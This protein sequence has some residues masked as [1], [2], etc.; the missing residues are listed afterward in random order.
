[1]SAPRVRAYE[2]ADEAEV[3][4]IFRATVAFGKPI[5]FDLTRMPAYERLCLDWFLGPGA[6][7]AGVLHDNGRVLGYIL[8]CTDLV[9]FRR[10]SVLAGASWVGTTLGRFLTGR[11]RGPEARFHLLRLRDGIEASQHAPPAPMPGYVH[12]NIH[13]EARTALGGLL[14]ARYADQRCRE[15]GLPGWYA[16]MNAKPGTRSGALAAGGITTVHRQPNHTLA[17]LAGHPVERLTIVRELP[18]GSASGAQRAGARPSWRPARPP[19]RPVGE[20]AAAPGEP[21]GSERPAGQA[22][23]P[24]ADEPGPAADLGAAPPRRVVG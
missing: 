2:P 16:E 12:L 6:A 13:F 18:A 23:D 20:H 4:A 24:P 17:W 11:L 19:L 5:P 15:A 10:W 8:V 1:M 14:L 7:D 21:D 3:R 9:A 22:G